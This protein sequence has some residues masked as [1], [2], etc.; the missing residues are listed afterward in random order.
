MGLDAVVYRHR[1]HL[2][3][4]DELKDAL[5]DEPTGEVYLPEERPNRN[6]PPDFFVALHRRLGNLETICRLRSELEEIV[7]HKNTDIQQ[8]WLSSAFHAG[9]VIPLADLAKLEGEIDLIRQNSR[10]RASREVEV[11]LQNL[12]ELIAAAK[13]EGNPIVFT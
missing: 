4:D 8:K 2:T 5:V 12:S 10:G 7:G 11:F 3:L 6:C 1:S 9:D 13:Y